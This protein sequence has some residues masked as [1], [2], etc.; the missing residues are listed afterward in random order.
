MLEQGG[1]LVC[2]IQKR[3]L[4][5]WS[6]EMTLALIGLYKTA[7]E[8]LFQQSQHQEG[9]R[10]GTHLHY[11]KHSQVQKILRHLPLKVFSK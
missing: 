9:G 8:L 4:A 10:M 5:A 6:K 2:V 7:Y 1:L 3:A 11:A